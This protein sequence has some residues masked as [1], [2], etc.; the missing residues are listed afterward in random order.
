MPNDG[1]GFNSGL[2]NRVMPNNV[3]AYRLSQFSGKVNGTNCQLPAHPTA[4]PGTGL[5][6]TSELNSMKTQNKEQFNEND[7]NNEMYGVPSK[8][9][10]PYYTLEERPLTATSAV[11]QAPTHYSNYVMP[12]GTDKRTTTNVEFG[13]SIKV[14]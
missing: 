12:S 10:T 13:Q 1:Q 8:N 14:K 4:L 5:A 6:F 11:T 7:E 9:K 2:Q 3:N